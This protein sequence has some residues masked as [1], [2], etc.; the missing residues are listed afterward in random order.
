MTVSTTKIIAENTLILSQIIQNICEKNCL[1]QSS[2]DFL[3]KTQFTILKILCATG[4][5]SVSEL[6]N[7]LH[8]SRAAASKNI[9][10]LVKNK[11]V[12]RKV[13]KEDRRTVVI[14]LLN[15]GIS[16]IK[17]YDSLRLENQERILKKF[18][19]NEKKE[20]A[21]LLDKYILLYLENET[22]ADLICLQ[23][24]GRIGEECSLGK[25]K[26]NC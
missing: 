11:F 12:S 18:S 5:C 7:V 22:N 23:C 6:A 21:K 10:I 8:I 14:E 24:D 20:F 13:I 9:E 19:A 25:H 16:V 15:G 4:S 3:T 17:K 26:S 2:P 1:K